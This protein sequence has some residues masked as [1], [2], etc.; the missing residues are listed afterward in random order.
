MALDSSPS[1]QSS[2]AARARPLSRREALALLGASG[3]ALAAGMT[4]RPGCA[5]STSGGAVPA[6][7][8]R[9]EQTEGPF[10][11]DAALNRSDIR[12]DPRTGENRAGVALRLTFLVSQLTG[13]NCAP[14]PDARVDVWH[15]DATGRYS[16]VRG[17]G[18]G[19]SSAGQQ[20][21]RGYQLT[22]GAGSAQFLTIFPGWYGGRAVH[23]HFKIRP[24]PASAPRLAFTSQLYFDAALTAR[25]FALEPYATRGQRWLRNDE[26]GIFRD[27][28]RQLL[29]A[30]EPDGPGYAAAFAVGLQA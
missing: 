19:P 6:C 3:A 21:L 2:V 10:F 14:L 27:G 13:T 1:M 30:A 11:V 29:L 4:P 15:A 26:D 20:F 24:A 12:S 28:G 17:S 23:L 25:V 16:D 7:I 18:F 22:D 9:P 8:A 5:Q